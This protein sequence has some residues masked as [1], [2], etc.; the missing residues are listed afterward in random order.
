[1]DSVPENTQNLERCF[2]AYIFLE[3]ISLYIGPI[4]D[5][6]HCNTILGRNITKDV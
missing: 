5:G 4:L 6:R 2:L 3:Y 1:M